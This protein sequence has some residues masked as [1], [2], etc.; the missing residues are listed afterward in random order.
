MAKYCISFEH[1]FHGRTLGAL[2]LTN[3]KKVHKQHYFSIP[4]KRLPYTEEA[5][6]AL[7]DILERECSAQEIAC[8]II[9]PMQGEGG[10]TIPSLIMAHLRMFTMSYARMRT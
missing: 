2:S 1:A 7:L 9:E 5:A 4:T 3:T 10:Y 8:I 6:F